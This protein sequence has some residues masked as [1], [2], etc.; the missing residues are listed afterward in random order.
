MPTTDKIIQMQQQG[1]SD[2]DII[3]NLRNEGLSQKDI[4][5]SLAQVKI[6]MAVSQGENSYQE[7]NAPQTMQEQYS[8]SQQY[9]QPVAQYAPSPQ[10]YAPQEYQGQ[11]AAYPQDGQQ[12]Y[13]PEQPSMSI[14]TI[15]DIVERIVSEK[16]KEINQ[17]IK[18]STEFK[19]KTEEDI[20][21]IKERLKRIESTIDSLQ[22]SVISKVGE[23]G[24]S[25]GLIHK[26]LENLH[27]TVSN[28][29]NPLIDKYNELKKIN[30]N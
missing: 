22:R 27:G 21:E 11:Q 10:Q 5:D 28:L 4:S 13:A 15:S 29:M 25:T 1:M 6:K 30:K 9:E 24:Q 3:K 7:S 2:G 12:Y 23:F 17:K 14:D 20:L 18:S 16:L 26:D 8:P 19:T